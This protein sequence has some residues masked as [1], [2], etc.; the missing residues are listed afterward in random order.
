[1]EENPA[2]DEEDEEV[3]FVMV[4]YKEKEGIV[5]DGSKS[6]GK[7]HWYTLDEWCAPP[8][9]DKQ[10]ERGEVSSQ[11][12]SQNGPQQAQNQKRQLAAMHTAAKS[13]SKDAGGDVM[14]S[15]SGSDGNQRN[16]SVLHQGKVPCMDLRK[17][18]DGKS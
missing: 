12:R 3:H 13:A 7:D 9:E 2:D 8:P 17:G 11:G 18:V 6:K 10:E 1:M 4:Q 16:H 5:N 15:D 14:E